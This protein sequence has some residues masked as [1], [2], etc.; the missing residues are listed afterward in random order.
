[1][2]YFKL[3][4]LTFLL[5]TRSQGEQRWGEQNELQYTF[6]HGT[7][8]VWRRL[9][10]CVF[11]TRDLVTYAP[12]VQVFPFHHRHCERVSPLKEDGNRV[13]WEKCGTDICRREE[14]RKCQRLGVGVVIQQSKCADGRCM[15]MSIA[16]DLWCICVHA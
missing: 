10:H 8:E 11:M 9:F 16:L 7:L 4:L 3:V 5:V 13:V 15:Q 2:N 12:Y 6:P 1:M 14:Y